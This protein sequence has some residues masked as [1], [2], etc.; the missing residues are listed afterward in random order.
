MERCRAMAMAMAMRGAVVL[1]LALAGDGALASS[2]ASVVQ[3][4]TPSAV[5][6]VTAFDQLPGWRDDDQALAWDA[7]RRSCAVL[8]ARA[9]WR[10][11]CAQVQATRPSTAD[12]RA[13]FE[14][15]FTP[16][17]VLAPDA[18]DQ[19]PVTGYFEPL[20]DG[21]SD[22]S[23]DY[24]VP[25]YGMPRDMAVL[26][27][28]RVPAALRRAVVQVVPDGAVLSVRAD[29]S[30]G[31][32]RLDLGRCAAEAVDRRLRLRLV[33]AGDASYAEPYPARADIDALGP[34]GLDAPVLAWVRD[35]LALYAMQM[36]GSG[37]IRMADG[38]VLRLQYAE[39]N[40]R[41]F[42]PLRIAA[43][44]RTGALMR[45]GG[46]EPRG[47]D[48]FELLADDAPAP[49]SAPAPVM[50][51]LRPR[52]G[53]P[54]VDSM[55]QALLG[56]AARPSATKPQRCAEAAC[57]SR[58]VEAAAAPDG[59]AAAARIAIADPSFVFFRMSPDQSPV[60]GPPG[61]LGVPLTAGRSVAVDPRVMPLG[62]P[63]YLSARG[64]NDD[65]AAAGLRQ[66]T[67]AQDTGGAIRGPLRLDVF[68]GYGHAAGQRARRTNF[69]GE[70]WV[71]LPRA[72]AERLSLASAVMRSGSARRAAVVCLAEDDPYCDADAQ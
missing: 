60:P 30:A 15:R 36:Q 59:S 23:A 33:R 63:V 1:L 34:G 20:L 62:Y 8:A 25:V 38:K 17:R 7:L 71:L 19:G 54:A 18:A 44:P 6:R 5:F 53:D 66:L 31:G 27:L 9:A 42:R 39:Q 50:R 37:R 2:E 57:S 64:A 16:V 10:D 68:W 67:F 65:A 69:Q 43:R 12:A 32:Y 70:M 61:A 58:Q 29:A 14:A 21:R 24:G 51:S 46:Q 4:R 26:D 11:V 48:E 41:P 13:F 72:E 55:V 40:G 56:N 52:A 3:W 22:R 45:D 28:R 49:A 35:P 47:A